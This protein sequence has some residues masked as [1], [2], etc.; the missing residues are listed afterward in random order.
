MEKM[1][2]EDN[3]YGQNKQDK[4]NNFYS[5]AN[6]CLDHLPFFDR[7]LVFE[8]SNPEPLRIKKSD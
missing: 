4:K 8:P 1:V 2:N 7:L 5:F 3:P 6:Q